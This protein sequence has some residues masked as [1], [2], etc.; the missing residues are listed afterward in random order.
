MFAAFKR[1]AFFE[2]ALTLELKK[3]SHLVHS[4]NKCSGGIKRDYFQLGLFLLSLP[5]WSL[6]KVV[7]HYA[8]YN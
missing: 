8:K 4:M 5:C 7:G 6:E 3:E 2:K 1:C